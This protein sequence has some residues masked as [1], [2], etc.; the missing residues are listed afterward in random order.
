MSQRTLVDAGQGNGIAFLPWCQNP[1]EMA[2]LT[3]THSSLPCI[4]KGMKTVETES[5]V[6]RREKCAL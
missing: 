3:Y 1:D 4:G 2:L 5:W 6:L